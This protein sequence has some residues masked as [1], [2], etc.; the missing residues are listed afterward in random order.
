MNA[1]VPVINQPR[2]LVLRGLLLLAVAGLAYRAFYL[3]VLQTPFLQDKAANRHVR[4]LDEHAHRGMV[5]DRNGEPLAISTAV[6]SLWAD[7]TEFVDAK[8][9]WHQLARLLAIP[10]GDLEQL[11]GQRLQR[12]FVYVKRRLTPRLAQ[13]VKALDLPGLYLQREYRRYY[14]T[15]EVSGHLLGFT[16]IDDQGQ[17]GLELQFESMLSGQR[18]QIRVVQDRYQRWIQPVE[19]L[20]AATPGSDLAVT[21]DKRLQYLAYRELKAAVH[22]HQA[23]SGSVVLMDIPSGEILAM[24]N[25]P[26]F[27]P[28]E[29]SSRKPAL[30]RNRAV[31]DVFEP[32]S[33][34]KPFIVAAALQQGVYKVGS[35]IDTS[36]GEIEVSGHKIR[37][38]RSLGFIALGMEAF[39]IED[40]LIDFGFGR[41]TDSRLP[42]ESDGILVPSHR[43]RKLD[44]ATLAFGYGLSVTPVQLA[45]AYAVLGNHGRDLGVQIV[46]RQGPDSFRQI[47]RPEVADSVVSM[48]ESVVSPEGTG[49][50][51]AIENYR[52]AGKTGT[53]HLFR[54]GGYD[55]ERYVA[56]FAGVAPASSPRLAMVVTIH[57]PKGEAYYAGDVA[58]PVFAR[59][60]ERALRLLQVPPDGDLPTTRLSDAAG[61]TA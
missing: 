58:A 27:N 20:Q 15:G 46:R 40:L 57:D 19:S 59:V 50:A 55:K 24:V 49:G 25:Q 34:I 32:G 38:H 42:G 44:Q 13:Q 12:R 2:E 11:I 6:D 33:T 43:W 7:P 60:M 35:R 3:Q 41:S 16:N 29:S 14:P 21:L 17:E 56:T 18:G 52:V 5:V 22:L 51:A 48:L 23:S 61:A 47:L 31:T 9:Q 45:R 28:N 30:F 53:A 36:P 4:V 8:P 54:N 1:A 26:S 37:D 39:Q 10:D